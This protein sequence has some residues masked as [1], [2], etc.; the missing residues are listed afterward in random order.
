LASDVQSR[1]GLTDCALLLPQAYGHTLKAFYTAFPEFKTNDLYL[2]GESY[3][4]QCESLRCTGTATASRTLRCPCHVVS[5][6]CCLG[7]A[8]HASPRHLLTAVDIPN[9]ATYILNNMAAELPLKG[10]L[11]GNGTRCDSLILCHAYCRQHSI[12]SLLR[13]HNEHLHLL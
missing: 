11:V 9:I 6:A 3:A 4:G 12:V 10:I 2:S 8:A 1:T 7:S 5:A 13:C